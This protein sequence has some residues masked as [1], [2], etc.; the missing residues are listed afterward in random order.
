MTTPPTVAELWRYPV[1]SLQGEQ[2]GQLTFGPQN[3]AGDRRYALRNADD[4]TVL[5]A[6]RVPA[7]FA[8]SARW[9]DGEVVLGV[10]GHGDIAAGDERVHAAVSAWLGRSA[11]VTPVPEGEIDLGRDSIWPEVGAFVDLASAHL[12]TTA[13]LAA[14]AR[15]EPDADWDVRRFRPSALIAAGDDDG[16]VEE[17]WVGHRVR[18]GAVE[19]EVQQ[20]CERCGMVTQPQPALAARAS[21]AR[22]KG[23]YRVLREQHDTNLGVYARIVVPGEVHVGDPVTVAPDS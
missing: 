8:G 1:K 11:R 22:D 10:P 12:L 13:S 19:V 17:G 20:P 9:V 6:K 21:L 15:L 5:S 4:G 7:L 16:F 18:V 2:L 14:M 3:V 23:V